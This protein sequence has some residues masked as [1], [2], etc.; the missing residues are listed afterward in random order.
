[1][2]YWTGNS[3]LL[4]EYIQQSE[5]HK[6]STCA[7]IG[8]VAFAGLS[9]RT[10]G[11]DDLHFTVYDS[12]SDSGVKLL[13]GDFIVPGSAN[14]WAFSLNPNLMGWNGI[15]IKMSGDGGEFQLLYNK[16]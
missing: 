1:M 13:P 12:T 6:S 4:V 2:S 14:L 3:G 5:T 10:N 9:V 16:G 11:T 7:R 8:P 15:Y